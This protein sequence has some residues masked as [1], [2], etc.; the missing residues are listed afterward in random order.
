MCELGDLSTQG[1]IKEYLFVGVGE[2]ILSTD[3]VRDS[4]FNVIDDN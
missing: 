1:F 2:V 4:H 3:H